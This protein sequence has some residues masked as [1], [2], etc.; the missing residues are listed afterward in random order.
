MKKHLFFE[1]IFFLS[2]FSVTLAQDTSKRVIRIPDEVFTRRQ[3][4]APMI[5]LIA[6]RN[7]VQIREQVKFTLLP[8]D[9]TGRSNFTYT[10]NFGDETQAVKENGKSYFLHEYRSVG[11]FTVSVSIDIPPGIE[12]F[13]PTPVMA[14]EITLQVENVSL[15]V[16]P[17]NVEVGQTVSFETKFNSIDKNLRYNFDFGDNSTSGWL[18]DQNTTHTYS[19]SGTYFASAEINGLD[20]NSLYPIAT[21]SEIQINV[22]SPLS[23]TLTADNISPK[24]YDKITLTTSSNRQESGLEYWFNFGDNRPIQKS[25]RPVISKMYTEPGDYKLS[26]QLAANG[27]PLE[28]FSVIQIKVLPI[29]VELIA[30]NT[31]VFVGDIIT[32]SALTNSTNRDIKYFFNYGDNGEVTVSNIS[33]INHIYLEPGNFTASVQVA[34]N[35]VPITNTARLDIT[36]SP[37]IIVTLRANKPNAIEGEKIKFKAITSSANND[38]RYE[39][40]FGDNATTQTISDS[41]ISHIYLKRGNYTT[42]VKLIKNGRV[43]SQSNLPINISSR[44][45]LVD[46][47]V[48]KPD[49]QPGDTLTFTASSNYHN[50]DL[51]YL[52]DFG[53]NTLVQFTND[54]IIQHAYINPRNFTASVQL[55]LNNIRQA[56]DSVA[57]RINLLPPDTVS[58]LVEPDTVE[59]GDT[60]TFT[61]STNFKGRLEYEFYFGDNFEPKRTRENKIQ[62]VYPDSG[63]FTVFVK[64]FQKDNKITKSEEH[65]VIVKLP[66]KPDWWP[67]IL[68]GI[69]IIAAGYLIRKWYFKSLGITFHPY[70]DKGLSNI[71]EPK[72]FSINYEIHFNP[73]LANANNLLKPQEENLIKSKTVKP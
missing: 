56:Q 29:T 5:T 17:T 69:A 48:D 41:T 6:D 54:S 16:E 51:E 39:F 1:L 22:K 36:I 19:Q 64:L 24:A 63:M 2:V 61:A 33:S 30:G 73:N 26:V 38:F 32:F 57:V 45:Y 10:I 14:N 27:N 34:I 52:F 12:I 49:S 65:Y 20:G 46:L 59:T 4:Q 70:P 25:L 47:K 35:S 53:D 44:Q 13:D 67:Y 62:F 72:K 42:S 3:Q 43:L 68:G 15:F 7:P 55:L 37:Q 40:N 66:S 11:P 50:I 58:L 31:N 18:T 23:V 60:I 71:K 21:T 28:V 9:I 8:E